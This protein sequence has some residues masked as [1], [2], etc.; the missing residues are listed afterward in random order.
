M[1][2]FALALLLVAPLASAQEGDLP[3][4]TDEEWKVAYDRFRAAVQVT[5]P[6]ARAAAIADLAAV[7]HPKAF[8][9]LCQLARS[10]DA[11]VAEAAISARFDQPFE[12]RIREALLADFEFFHRKRMDPHLAAAASGLGR[13]K[14]PK[15]VEALLD[16]LH[17]PDY[18]VVKAALRSIASIED[19]GVVPKL[20]VFLETVSP[21]QDERRMHPP[22]FNWERFEALEADVLAAMK[23]LTGASHKDE[24]DWRR[25]F[26]EHKKD[27]PSRY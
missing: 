5:A 16:V 2:R 3:L 8:Q 11:A 26:N 12:A 7:H 9:L 22:A 24:E 6:E 10:E 14:D 23:K 4:A 17:Y 25:W 27:F 1:R 18:E 21:N 20:L 19:K 15:A 13:V